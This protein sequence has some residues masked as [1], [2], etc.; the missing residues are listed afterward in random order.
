M[1]TAARPHQRRETS[2]AH[3]HRNTGVVHRYSEG[4]FD[5]RV[6]GPRRRAA[7][8]D[9]TMSLTHGWIP[10]LA[11]AIAAMVVF[12]AIGRRSRPLAA[13]DAADGTDRR[14]RTRRGGPL[15]HRRSRTGRRSCAPRPLGVDRG[16]RADHRDRRTGVARRCVV[17]PR[18]LS[19][20]SAP[21]LAVR[22]VDAQH[23]GGLSAH[24]ELSVAPARPERRCRA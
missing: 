11:Q 5:D 1:E 3:V 20:R 16:D 4:G 21:V 6:C 10:L 24:C 15:V 18:H 13:A 23:V 2:V 8:G 14:S 12:F 9:I 22:C 7:S 17:A 19:P